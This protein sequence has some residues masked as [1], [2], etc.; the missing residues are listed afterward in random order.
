MSVR[1]AFMAAAFGLLAACTDTSA[2]PEASDGA[3]DDPLTRAS[4]DGFEVIDGSLDPADEVTEGDG[5]ELVGSGERMENL[6]TLVLVTDP[7]ELEGVWATHG[8][9]G[10]PPS[11]DYGDQAVVFVTIPTDCAFVLRDVVLD[12]DA[13]DGSPATVT[14]LDLQAQV[15]GTC[16]DDTDTTGRDL[17]LAVDREFVDDRRVAIVRGEV[18]VGAVAQP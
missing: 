1:L 5:W 12:P 9:D 17:A 4:T 11:V 13:G 10:D 14:E 8:M 3:S 18:P 2:G 15:D 16:G 6:R 7:S